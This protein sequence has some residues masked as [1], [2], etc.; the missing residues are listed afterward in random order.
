MVLSLS[1]FVYAMNYEPFTWRPSPELLTKSQIEEIFT[2]HDI[3]LIQTMLLLREIPSQFL[4]TDNIPKLEKLISST[5]DGYSSEIE[6]G[7]ILSV[8]KSQKTCLN[9]EEKKIFLVLRILSFRMLSTPTRFGRMPEIFRCINRSNITDYVSENEIY[10]YFG[11]CPSYQFFCSVIFFLYKNSIESQVSSD[12]FIKEIN[13]LFG[14]QY[15]E[16]PQMLEQD[17]S[18][19]CFPKRFGCSPMP[20]HVL[21]TQKKTTFR[22]TKKE[23]GTVPLPQELSFTTAA[24]TDFEFPLDFGKEDDEFSRKFEFFQD[25]CNPESHSTLSGQPSTQTFESE[26]LPED[27]PQEDLNKVLELIKKKYSDKTIAMKLGITKVRAKEMREELALKFIVEGKLSDEAIAEIIRITEARVRKLS[28]EQALKL[29]ENNMMLDDKTIA[30]VTGVPE[31]RV[32][33]SREILVLKLFE[34]NMML[35]DKTI[36]G[37]TGVPE[38]RVGELREEQVL[39]LF[40]RNKSLNNKTIARRTGVP[41]ARVEELIKESKEKR[42]LKLIEKNTM[43]DDETIARVTGVPEARVKELI[44]E[45]R[46]EQALKFIEKNMMP[47]D[48]TIAGIVIVPEARIKELREILVLK[49]IENMG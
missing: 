25:F 8:L 20:Y 37:E 18:I 29:F 43:P 9:F 30:E 24:T 41:E 23:F 40:E 42:A 1:A 3:K 32:K 11:L 17:E 39:K 6:I 35:D 14:T 4:E 19:R 27:T 22:V 28:E 21:P 15:K 47:D 2:S 13:N 10:N 38:A 46:E 49:L 34:N 36:A 48:E 45:S 16:G 26:R 31:A 33:K 44:K 12:K 7:K 5:I